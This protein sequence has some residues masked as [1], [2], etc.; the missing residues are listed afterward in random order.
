M[1]YAIILPDGAAD[2]SLAQ[3]G[4]RT[5][6]EVARIPHM[7]WIAAHGRLGRVRTIPSGF[8]PGTDVGTLA[9]FGY[10]PHESYT[11]RAPIEAAAKGLRVRPDEIIF[12]C[13]FVTVLDGRMKS[14]NAGH[15]TQP[16]ADPL[17]AD[18][19]RLACAGEPALAGCVF[20]VGVSYRNLLV[21]SD[22]AGLQ[23]R[24][25]P[26][27]DIP[28]HPVNWVRRSA[29]AEPV[30]GIWLWGQGRP[31]AL[32]PFVRRFGVR[33]AVI[34]AVDIIRGLAAMMG[35]DRIDVPGATGYLDTNYA[36][37]GAYAVRALEEYD[38]VVVH[39]EA[40]DEA[41]H[42]GNAEEKIKALERL[43]EH[44]VGPVLTALRRYPAWRIL[45]APDH[46]TSTA[47]TQHADPPPPFCLAGRGVP[48]G[49]A[50]AFHERAAAAQELY[51]PP[52]RL[53]DE[54]FTR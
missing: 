37:K 19:N 52:A 8:L 27:H 7:D 25:T 50:A 34:A 46:V 54:F 36:G 51:D 5:P 28:D 3:L 20:H 2:D 44:V 11:G 33:A 43:D 45:I 12:R 18:L 24:C 49:G 21:A 42:L 30:T 15:I 6:L 10:D 53:M 16:E 39:V 38:L 29:G 17:I 14:F 23:L 4:G 22:A 13:N 9:V 35:M 48:A 40:P 31:K 1:K 26:P 32:E 41:A 47:T